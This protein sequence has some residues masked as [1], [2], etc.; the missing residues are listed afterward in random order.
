MTGDRLPV[1]AIGGLGGSGTRVFA[2]MLQHA[3][4]AIGSDLNKAL[5]NLW[6]TALFKR[7]HWSVE[8][9]QPAEVA[10]AVRLFTTAMQ[11]GLNGGIGAADRALLRALQRELPP[12]GTWGNGARAPVI[13]RLLASQGR[14][15]GPLHW[16]WK[17]P[18]THIFLPYLDSLL[19][20]F[21]YIHILRDG[22]DMAF[23][24]NTWQMRHW[25]HLY[26]LHPAPDEPA[27]LRQMRYW[28]AA[29][30]RAI[31]YGRTQMGAR[32]MVIRYE[33]FC[34]TPEPYWQRIRHFAGIDGTA[35][36]PPGL[37]KPSTIGRA[38][39]HDLSL[40]PQDLLDA[41][42]DLQRDLAPAPLPV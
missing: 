10:G 24:G 6:F 3:G 27:P 19:P 21:R 5:D 25:G 8:R 41:V 15:D 22:H 4:I 32:F 33:D 26:G 17:E 13:D 1:I 35:P 34:A 31:A 7:R 37:V 11:H 42:A 28:L 9:P 2:A 23:S 38:R 40:F 18:N 36:L 39:D 16:G 20:G 14:S 29:N 30:R 12:D